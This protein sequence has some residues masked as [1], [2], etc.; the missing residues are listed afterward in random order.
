MRYVFSLFIKVMCYSLANIVIE[1]GAFRK[2]AYISEPV[3][4]MVENWIE[5]IGQ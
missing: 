3:P 4:M 5:K 2:T 1:V